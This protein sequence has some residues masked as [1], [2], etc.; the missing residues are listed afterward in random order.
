MITPGKVGLITESLTWGEGSGEDTEGKGI[1]VSRWG[2]KKRDKGKEGDR[3]RTWR[4]GR[5]WIEE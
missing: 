2:K 3:G 5:K 1:G 4:K